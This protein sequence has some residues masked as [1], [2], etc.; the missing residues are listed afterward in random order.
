[1]DCGGAFTRKDRHE[2]LHPQIVLENSADTIW[3]PRRPGD[4]STTAPDDVLERVE[5]EFLSTVDDDLEIWRYQS[6]IEH[7]AYS[8]VDAKGYAALRTWSQ[9]FYDIG[10]DE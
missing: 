1:M 4:G 7:P 8:N 3:W 6:W 9:R 5:Q 10:P 2:R